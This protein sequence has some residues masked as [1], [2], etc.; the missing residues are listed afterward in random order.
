MLRGT[1]GMD[2]SSAMARG[3]RHQKS[4]YSTVSAVLVLGF[5]G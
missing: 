2:M 4:K 5:L 1:G 3:N